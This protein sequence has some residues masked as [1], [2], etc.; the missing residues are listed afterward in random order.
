[1]LVAG[2][3]DGQRIVVVALGVVTYLTVRHQFLQ[4]IQENGDDTVQDNADDDDESEMD[5]DDPLAPVVRASSYAMFQS[6]C[7]MKV[8]CA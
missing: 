5:D 1:M 7:K 4:A 8:V 6:L 2:I 3:Y